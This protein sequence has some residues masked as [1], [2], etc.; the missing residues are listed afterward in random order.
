MMLS[1]GDLDRRITIQQPLTGIDATGT[2]NRGYSDLAT[3]WAKQIDVK[4]DELIDA[5]R[6]ISKLDKIFTIRYRNDVTPEMRLLFEGVAYDIHAITEEGR[7]IGLNIL[8]RAV[9]P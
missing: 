5:D 3:V 1:A 4:Q 9:D 7:R 2:P 8:A 6:T